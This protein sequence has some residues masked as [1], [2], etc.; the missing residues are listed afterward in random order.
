MGMTGRLAGVA[1]V[2]WVAAVAAGTA[3]VHGQQAPASEPRIW[4]GIYTD[5]QAERG[6]AI[7][8]TACIRCH[9]ADLAGTTAPALK[10][11]RFQT[12]W[13][14]DVLDRLFGKIR[15]TMPP[16][17]GTSLDDK[18]KL[19]IVAYILQT[20]GYPAGPAELAVGSTDLASAQILRKG[21]QAAIQNFSLVQTVGCLTRGERNTWN[22]TRTAEPVATRDDAPTEASLAAAA[23]QPLGS[24]R[25]LLLS[26][27]MYGAESQAGRKVEARGLVYSEPGNDRLTVT[28]LKAVGAGCAE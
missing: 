12:S 24:R 21:Q 8:N 18:Q 23:S 6:K 25:F 15:D 7:F 17:F 2:V 20:N 9:G 4:Q 16:N 22:L 19:D 26:A 10:G 11:D 1:V 13:G 14:G 5:A 27:G 28:S 3:R